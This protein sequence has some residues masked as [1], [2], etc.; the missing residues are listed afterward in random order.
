MHDRDG[1]CAGAFEGGVHV[2]P[3]RVY[4]E[5][6]DA[7]G[8]VYYA[9][10]LKFAERA[11]TEMMHL[12]DAGYREIVRDEGLAFAVRRCEV[13]FLAPARLDDVLEVRTRLLAERGASLSAEQVIR[14]EG[15]D[16]ARL[17]V[18]LACIG[19]A[20]RPARIPEGLRSR[21]RA[22]ARG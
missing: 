19:S 3:V 12:L 17:H 6:T 8:I 1:P 5:D 18:R 22:L 13:D 4:Y 15:R 16:I 10:Y 2:F 14:R 21:M 9:N 20:G 11:R 7:G